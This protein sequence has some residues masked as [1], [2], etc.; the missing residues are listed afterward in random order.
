MSKILS[1]KTNEKIPILAKRKTK[2][3]KDYEEYNEQKEENKVHRYEWKRKRENFRV[4]SDTSTLDFERQL[5]KVAARGVVALF[6][7]I[8][9]AK[10]TTGATTDCNEHTKSLATV[11]S[12]FPELAKKMIQPRRKNQDNGI[13]AEYDH[14]MSMQTKLT[15]ITYPKPNRESSKGDSA[16]LKGSNTTAKS[17]KVQIRP[18]RVNRS[19]RSWGTAISK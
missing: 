9:E 10:R 2:F 3:M 5:R 4:L 8:S 14:E 1:Q 12:D 17:E 15:R 18:S 7:A 16:S 13:K 6:N 19:G 11:Q